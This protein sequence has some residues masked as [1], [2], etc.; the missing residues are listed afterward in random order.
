MPSVPQSLLWISL[1]VLWL[2]VL[3]PM[4]ISKRDAVRRTSDVALATRVLNSGVARKLRKGPATGHRSDPDWRPIDEDNDEFE[5]AA[6]PAEKGVGASVAPEAP[7]APVAS[8]ALE[9]PEAP[10]APVASEALVAP[11]QPVAPEQDYLDVDVVE[12]DS[13]ALPV[14]GLAAAQRGEAVADA[15]ARAQAVADAAA[16]AE[17]DAEA[18]AEPQEEPSAEADA[19]EEPSAGDEHVEDTSGLEASDE[20]AMA[21][22]VVSRRRLYESKTAAAVSARKY[23]F[24]TRVLSVMTLILVATTAAAFTVWPD[25]WWAC[26]TAGVITTLYLVYLRRQTRIEERLRRRRM[27]RMARSRLGVQNTADRDYDVPSR[28]RRHGS[29]VLEIDDED[30]NFEHL[31]HAPDSTGYHLPKAAGQ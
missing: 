27:Q 29:V 17:A 22:P 7:I 1:V 24:R 11:E 20:P 21:P 18:E 19:E 8:E 13:G 26:G 16:R 23:R 12:G 4:L 5:D 15:V 28:L 25:G 9:A 31:E 10:V 14:G 3:V 2:F 6:E 30:P